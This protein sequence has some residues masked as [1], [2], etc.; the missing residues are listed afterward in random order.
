MKPCALFGW[1]RICLASETPSDPGQAL[2]HANC[3]RACVASI[4]GGDNDTISYGFA[5]VATA[6]TILQTRKTEPN[7]HEAANVACVTV[8]VPSGGVRDHHRT[9]EIVL[10]VEKRRQYDGVVRDDVAVAQVTVVAIEVS[11]Q[12]TRE[13]TT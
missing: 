11:D 13:L 3:V 1:F 8:G 2:R 7:A 9:L 5:P 6:R 10:S 12:V 4:G